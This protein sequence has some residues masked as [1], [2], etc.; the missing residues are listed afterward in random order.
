MKIR[1]RRTGDLS[2]S[3]WVDRSVN[4]YLSKPLTGGSDQLVE[5]AEISSKR[6]FFPRNENLLKNELNKRLQ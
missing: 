2:R 3:K 4:Q 6:L 5:N 1:D